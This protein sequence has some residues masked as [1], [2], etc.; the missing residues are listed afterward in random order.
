[1]DLP[2]KRKLNGSTIFVFPAIVFVLFFCSCS[3]LKSGENEPVAYLFSYFTGNEPGE[4]AIRFAISTDGYIYRA[5]NKNEPVLD[6]KIISKSG[7]VRD[8]HILRCADGKTF[9]MVATDLYVPEMGWNNYA[10]IL[11]KSTDLIN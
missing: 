7:G 2:F 3:N 6:S 10:L 5:L 4:E 8:P 9:Y 1:M 11:L